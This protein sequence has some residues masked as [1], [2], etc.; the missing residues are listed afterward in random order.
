[1]WRCL[2]T[3][4]ILLASC[5]HVPAPPFISG[6]EQVVLPLSGRDVV[7]GY[8]VD[9]QTWVCT[10]SASCDVCRNVGPAPAE[11][12]I[13]VQHSNGQGNRFRRRSEPGATVTLCAPGVRLEQLAQVR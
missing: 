5:T 1:M 4:L 3:L 10:I 9:P 6:S 13:L 11:L 2:S 12:T 8:V 7:L